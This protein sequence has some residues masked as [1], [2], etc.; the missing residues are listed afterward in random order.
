MSVWLHC[1]TIN[2]PAHQD[3]LK[4]RLPNVTLKESNQPVMA[5]QSQGPP[6]AAAP[7]ARLV[8]AALCHIWCCATETLVAWR[9][10]FSVNA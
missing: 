7:E 9:I 2:L 6:D 4:G 1:C 3:H 5:T 10:L 8:D